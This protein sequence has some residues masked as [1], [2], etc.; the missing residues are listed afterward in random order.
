MSVSNI[1]SQL[2][3]VVLQQLLLELRQRHP[4]LRRTAAVIVETH[5][6]QLR[7]KK[8]SEK[9]KRGTYFHPSH[10]AGR[11][12]RWEEVLQSTFSQR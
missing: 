12:N 9:F 4:V 2:P 11:S 7:R 1:K 5:L 6:V 8:P 3:T 10:A